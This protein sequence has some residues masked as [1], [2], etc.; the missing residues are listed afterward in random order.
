MPNLVALSTV[1]QMSRT[2]VW[3]TDGGSIWWLCYSVTQG[4]I[5]ENFAIWGDPYSRRLGT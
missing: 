1:V 5:I 3:K 4:Q 2:Q